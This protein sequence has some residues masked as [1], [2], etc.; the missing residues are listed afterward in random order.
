MAAAAILDFENLK[1][2]TADT[3]RR[4]NLHHR[5]QFHRNRSSGSREIVIFRF[6]KM[7]AVRHLGFTVNL[8]IWT[9][10][11]EHLVVS[12]GVQNLVEIDAVVL[13][14][15]KFSYFARLA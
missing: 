2:L 5:A 1:N 3:V 13:K 14:I 4:V 8:F 7:A 15:C 6:F 9:T 11:E 10:H 12:I